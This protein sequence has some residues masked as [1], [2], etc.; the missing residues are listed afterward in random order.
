MSLRKLFDILYI[1][2]PF[3]LSQI[4]LTLYSF[5]NVLAVRFLASAGILHG[6][7]DQLVALTEAIY[8]LTGPVISAA[9]CWLAC[10]RFLIYGDTDR[11]FRPVF[12]TVAVFFF[13]GIT[14]QYALSL[15][16]TGM[17]AIFPAIFQA[18]QERLQDIGMVD[19]T[20]F[21][22][23]SGVVIAPIYEE[24]IY[25]KLTLSVARKSMPFWAANLLQAAIFGAAHMNLVQSSYAF[26]LGLILGYLFWRY[27][28]VIPG[29][30][31]HFFINLSGFFLVPGNLLTS[32]ILLAISAAALWAVLQ[33]QRQKA[34]A[35]YLF[36]KDREQHQPDSEA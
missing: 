11:G 29:I 21:S 19:P 9:I 3:I 10:R 6:T 30:L 5:G 32:V 14:I 35:Q 23:L 22:T 28:S 25:R 18:Y 17:S 15:L 4:A 27:R 34:P 33:I 1:F 2:V 7:A 13:L 36:R 31:L 12:Q 24:I 16:L 20:L 26:L 8:Y